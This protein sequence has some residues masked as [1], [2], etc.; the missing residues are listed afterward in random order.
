LIGD[1]A[2][3]CVDSTGVGDPIVEDCNATAGGVHGFKFT[4]TSKQQIMEGLAAVLQ[5][6]EVTFPAGWLRNELD[7]FEY[8]Y[9][10]SGVRYSAPEGLHDD[11]V[12]ALALAV[13]CKTTHRPVRLFGGACYAP[14]PG[15]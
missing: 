1:D 11:G 8:V 12:C 7:A 9:T 2:A 10:Q 4:A 6:R 5:R 14:P 13:H 15:R 3:A